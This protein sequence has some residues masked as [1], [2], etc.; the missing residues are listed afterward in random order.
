METNKEELRRIFRAGWMAC[1]SH[2]DPQSEIGGAPSQINADFIEYLKLNG[3]SISQPQ[4]YPSDLEMKKLHDYLEKEYA[5]GKIDHAGRYDIANRHL[6][7]HPDGEC[8]ET[9]DIYFRDTYCKSNK[10]EWEKTRMWLVW[11]RAIQGLVGVDKWQKI[12]DDEEKRFNGWWDREFSTFYDLPE[13]PKS[14]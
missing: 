5:E 1:E 12:I 9:V 8:G 6:Y 7:L 3:D 11:G 4:T 2:F 14:V 10:E 13:P